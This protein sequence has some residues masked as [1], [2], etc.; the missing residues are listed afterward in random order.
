MR[1]VRYDLTHRNYTSYS[2]YTPYS[3]QRAPLCALSRTRL[4]AVCPTW[5]QRTLPS[6]SQRTYAQVAYSPTAS[7]RSL[8]TLMTGDSP[9]SKLLHYTVPCRKRTLDV[10]CSS[11]PEAYTGTGDSQTLS[12]HE[13]NAKPGFLPTRILDGHIGVLPLLAS[14]AL[15]TLRSS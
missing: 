3:Q 6:H 9:I 13:A 5:D 4:F 7:W 12:A 10:R 8:D 14:H 1:L 15:A 2:D 11:P